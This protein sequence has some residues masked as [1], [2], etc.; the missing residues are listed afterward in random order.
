MQQNKHKISL[1]NLQARKQKI[2]TGK[3]FPIV[4]LSVYSASQA[5]LLDDICDFLLVG[6]SVAMVLYGMES[7][8]GAT[9]DMMINHGKA[10]ASNA[11]KA[12]VVVD[13]PFG[14][15]ETSKEQA[16]E[17]A[18][19]V[20]RETGAQGIKLEGGAHMA[21]AVEFLTERGIAVVAH[22]GLMPQHIATIGGYRYQGTNEEQELRLL[23][24]AHKLAAAGASMIVLEAI[25]EPVSRKITEQLDIPTIGIGASDACDGQ[26]LVID[27]ICGLGSIAGHKPRFVKEYVNIAD[28]I[29]Q[30]ATDYAQDVQQRKFPG[31]EHLY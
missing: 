15:Y 4:S 17:T 30:A 14:S 27:D 9:V 13:L 7:T 28:D 5:K 22:I 29:K 12:C 6:D 19:R 21:P 20:M 11:K 31:K 23:D 26:I 16:F 24:S 25:S 18:S 2:R 8:L 1:P 10:V 3:A